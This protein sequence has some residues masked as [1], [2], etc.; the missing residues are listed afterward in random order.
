MTS[1]A[2]A[3]RVH[4]GGIH[5]QTCSDGVKRVDVHVEATYSQVVVVVMVVVVVVVMVVMAVVVVATQPI[6]E[7]AGCFT[8]TLPNA[9]NI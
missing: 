7:D 3:S 5:L 6:I 4:R 8:T 2:T 9:P 1:V